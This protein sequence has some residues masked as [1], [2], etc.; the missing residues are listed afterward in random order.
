MLCPLCGK[1]R[2]KVVIRLSDG[3]H[4]KFCRGCLIRLR[5]GLNGTKKLV[6]RGV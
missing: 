3:T 1:S 6:S 5:K 4:K 2:A